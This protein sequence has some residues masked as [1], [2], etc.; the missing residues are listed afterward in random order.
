MANSSELSETICSLLQ[1][2]AGFE[3]INLLEIGPTLV[4]DL[5]FTQEQIV[6]A[7]FWLVS[8]KQIELLA[9]N[10]VRL[11]PKEPPENVYKRA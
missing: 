10:R 6:N 11:L 9:H 7:L 4:V 2:K 8:Q 5:G 3:P 1:E